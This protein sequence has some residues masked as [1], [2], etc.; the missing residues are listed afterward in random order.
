MVAAAF[1][2]V[3][4]KVKADKEQSS[5][6]RLKVGACKSRTLRYVSL[7]TFGTPTSALRRISSAAK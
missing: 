6:P 2:S 4:T 1:Q 7:P 5:Y 3:A